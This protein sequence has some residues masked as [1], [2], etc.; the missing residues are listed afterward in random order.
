MK[1]KVL[2]AVLAL[3]LAAAGYFYVDANYII[4]NQEETVMLIDNVNKLQEQAFQY[5]KSLCNKGS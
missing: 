3:G 2:A 4:L 1:K 5:G